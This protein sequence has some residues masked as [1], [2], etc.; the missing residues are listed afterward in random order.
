MRE[1]RLGALAIAIT[2]SATLVHQICTCHL[3][4]LQFSS[5]HNKSNLLAPPPFISLFVFL[6]TVIA[7]AENSNDDSITIRLLNKYY[8]ELEAVFIKREGRDPSEENLARERATYEAAEAKEYEMATK[9]LLQE[10]GVQPECRDV[11]RAVWTLMANAEY[12]SDYTTYFRRRLGPSYE[13][14][15]W[16]EMC[17]EHNK[18][19]PF[20]LTRSDPPLTNTPIKGQSLDPRQTNAG[21]MRFSPPTSTRPRSLSTVGQPKQKP[22]HQ[23][24]QSQS[25]QASPARLQSDTTAKMARLRAKT[26]ANITNKGPPQPPTEKPPK[27][28][29]EDLTNDSDSG[30]ESPLQPRKSQPPITMEKLPKQ[31]FFART[32]SNGSSS[33]N[34]RQPPVRPTSM[35]QGSM[36]SL[37]DSEDELNDVHLLDYRSPLRSSTSKDKPAA[38]TSRPLPSPSSTQKS[39]CTQ[40]TEQVSDDESYPRDFSAQRKYD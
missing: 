31:L 17:K 39:A 16:I 29:F 20:D 36:P 32:R 24:T 12:N 14:A 19:N 3:S 28:I 13:P 22:R 18:S 26:T 40:T 8:D 4:L 35:R 7:M 23:R 30:S 9:R 15:W 33:I 10:T 1:F 34:K 11:R 37:L 21:R 5:H 38:E 25:S 2:Y 27:K 6:C